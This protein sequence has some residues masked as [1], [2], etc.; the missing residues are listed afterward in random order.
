MLEKGISAYELK[1]NAKTSSAIYQWRK[2]TARDTDRTP[3]LRSIEKICDFF[4]V[5]LSNFFVFDEKEQRTVKNRSIKFVIDNL[6]DEQ[7]K[8]IELLLNE[9]KANKYKIRFELVVFYFISFISNASTINVV[10]IDFPS[11]VSRAIKLLL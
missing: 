3:S 6:T 4:G 9:F 2:N 1:E 10:S 5:T 11:H 7:I 8:I